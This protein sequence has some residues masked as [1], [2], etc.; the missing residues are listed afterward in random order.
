MKPEHEISRPPPED[1][2]ELW[3]RYPQVQDPTRL[4]EYR[5]FL[6]HVHLDLNEGMGEAQAPSLR[7]AI[8]A[9]LSA[10]L[11]KL[12]GQPVSFDD[13]YRGMRLVLA[14]TTS[15]RLDVLA[16]PECDLGEEGFRID[17]VGIDGIPCIT[18]LANTAAGLLYGAFRLLLE[19]AREIP[20]NALPR[21]EVPRVRHRLLNHWDNLDRTIERGYAG[22]SLWDW[23][24]LPD[25]ADPRLVDYA[26][27][28]AS[29]GINGAVLTNVNAHSLV[30]STEYLRKVKRLADVFRP[31]AIR[32]FLTARFS[33]PVELGKLT[34]ADPLDPNVRKFWREKVDE[35]YDLIPDFGGFLV[36]AN[37]EGQPGPQ[38]YARSHADGANV[39][40]EALEPHGGIV[41]WRAFVYDSAVP[42]DRAKQA[43]LEFEP[44]D[45]QF[46]HNA[47]VQVK[48][49]PIDFQPREP[50][51]PLFGRMPQTPL[52]LEFQITQEYLGQGTHWVFLAPLFEEV[53][54]ADTYAYGEH[55]SVARI[56]EGTRQG[57]RLSGMSGVSNIG[58]DRNWCGH[59]FAASNWYA[60]GRL[61]WNQ[62][63]EARTLAEE[64]VTL[65]HSRQRQV[66]E[67][68][69]DWM[70]RSRE[71]CVDYMTP[72]GL[73]HIM[74]WDHHAGPG[75][76]IDAGRPDWTSVYYHRADEVGIGFDRTS[77]GTNALEQ[78]A[79]EVRER[80]GSLQTCPE[81]LLLWFHHVAWDHR[82]RSGRTVWE[83]LCLH[84]Q[85]GVDE[86][87]RTARVWS[88]L[89]PWLDS[90][91][92]GQVVEL[93]RIQLRESRFWRDACILYF[94]T[95]SKRAIPEGVELTDAPLESYRDYTQY[96]VP[97][98]PERRLG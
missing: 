80:F 83:E 24:K 40:A 33:A 61:S 70:M 96:Y 9:E 84:Y 90:H 58:S 1:G 37:S 89:E 92:F 79:K 7:G 45:G 54:R 63:L 86:V 48:N 16:S 87:H 31:Y 42:V 60:F 29:I 32:V 34:T 56:V 35:I 71:A 22:F 78:Y 77:S 23:H 51:H 21:V 26:R 18:I 14:T 25:Y 49:G 67:P 94:Q 8:H 30:L 11:P 41:I 98:I 72:L 74:A 55:S 73:H 3:L 19:L 5:A 91:R 69:V 43:N 97:G 15:H 68:L 47:C 39:L 46:R 85:R 13:G 81:E 2:Y 52:F 4:A 20:V 12:L 27:A 62:E 50:F 76:W 53:L 93:L 44:L 88:T 36:K 28:N 66:V 38:N 17:A 6:T 95:Y 75:P 64:Y 57:H 82:L 10:A 59:P 65:A